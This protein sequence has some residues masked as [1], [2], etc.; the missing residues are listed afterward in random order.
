M[1]NTVAVGTY[2]LVNIDLTSTTDNSDAAEKEEVKQFVRDGC[3]CS[4]MCSALFSAG[5]Y[6]MM[7]DSC[8]ELTREERDIFVMGELSA[9]TF[10][11]T[12]TRMGS[13]HQEDPRR[14]YRSSFRHR[15]N[16]VNNYYNV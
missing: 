11:S 10:D 13:R 14:R 3:G 2:Q 7:R 8:N 1:I 12:S 15:G 9:T 5:E 16:K 4:T 6:M